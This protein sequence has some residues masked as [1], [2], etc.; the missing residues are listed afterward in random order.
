[1]AAITICSDFEAQKSLFLDI[2]FFLVAMVNGIYSLIYLF[3]FSLLVHRNASDFCE[4]IFYPATLLSSLISSTN[5]LILSLGFCMYSIMSSANRESFTSFLIWIPFIS[6][7]SL[8][9]VARTSRTI[10]NNG[11]ESGHP[12]LF[13]ILGGM[14]SV[15]HH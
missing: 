13:L 11:G 2:N 5:F 10:L 14:L 7:S 3:D 6:F 1:M 9:V 4:L 15:F 12:V 8:I